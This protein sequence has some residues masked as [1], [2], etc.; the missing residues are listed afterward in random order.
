MTLTFKELKAKNR[1]LVIEVHNH[2]GN[3]S[4]R[5]RQRYLRFH[6][7]CRIKLVLFFLTKE[8]FLASI[9]LANCYI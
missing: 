4:M 8:P 5:H 7:L 3:Y 6:E 9:K 1:N 2:D